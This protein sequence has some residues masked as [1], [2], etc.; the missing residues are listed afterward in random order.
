[1]CVA[2]A[3]DE[4]TVTIMC[5]YIDKYMI[6]EAKRN[7]RKDTAKDD[8]SV[9]YEDAFGLDNVI[10]S[11]TVAVEVVED[12]ADDAAVDETTLIL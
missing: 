7:P 9:D 4:G 11:D 5:A 3:Y 12:V 8:I 10:D 2:L 1:M 6:I